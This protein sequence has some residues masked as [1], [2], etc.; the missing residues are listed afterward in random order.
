MSYVKK[1]NELGLIHNMI[2]SSNVKCEV[3][4]ESISTKKSCKS[5]ERESELL[6][7]IHSDL[8]DLKNTMTRGGK[9]Y[10]IIFV[11][12][13]SRYTVLYLPRSKDEACDMFIK[14]KSEVEKSVE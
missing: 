12:D 7:L 8:G 1:M 5:V 6:G 11:D 3:C 9:K 10:H 4:V 14:F 13:F 2:D